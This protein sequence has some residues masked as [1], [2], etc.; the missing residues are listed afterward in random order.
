[1]E[2][3]RSRLV[4]WRPGIDVAVLSADQTKELVVTDRPRGVKF[5]LGENVK[6]SDGRFP[7]TRMGVEAVLIRAFSVFF[8]LINLAEHNYARR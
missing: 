2:T 8:D 6:R 1:M 7:N 4:T 5:A 3:A